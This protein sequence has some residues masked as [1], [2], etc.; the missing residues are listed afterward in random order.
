MNYIENRQLD[1]MSTQNESVKMFDNQFLESFT[2]V[3]PYH[4]LA[5]WVPVICYFIYKALFISQ[6][7]IMMTGSL[8]IA[9]MAIWTL[10]EYW[11]HRIFFH[12]ADESK[13]WSI[14]MNF[15]VHG[16]HHNYPNDKTRL[17]MP[18]VAGILI[19]Q[20][21]YWPLLL[22]AG[23]NTAALFAGI[24]LGYIAYDMVHYATHHSTSQNKLFKILKRHHLKH[25]FNNHDLDFGVTNT[26]WDKVFGTKS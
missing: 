9:G 23:A 1:C 18:P 10:L 11:L 13:P 26:F 16:V 2:H 12:Y 24:I 8:M 17:V 20:V 7:S 6:T 22:L 3:T 15:F 14:K 21:V 25:H 5:V 19:S 4:V